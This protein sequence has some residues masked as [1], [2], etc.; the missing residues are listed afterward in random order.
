MAKAKTVFFCSECGNESLKWVGKCPGCGSWNTMVEE[1]KK[2]KS[3][4]NGLFQKEHSH[5]PNKITTINT[6]DA[7]RYHTSYQEFNRVLGGGIVRG[8][9]VLIGGDPGIGKS[10]L[11]LQVAANV[12]TKDTVLYVTGEESEQQIKNRAE[13]LGLTPDQLYIYSENNTH[14]I[15]KHI[16][17][18]NPSLVIVDSIQTVF[19]PDITSAPGS[20]SQV[21]E[22]TSNFMRL[23]KTKQIPIF[24]VGHVTKDGAIAGP[25]VLEHMVDTVL[26]FEGER[27]NTYR[28]LRAVK[29]RFGS[30]N[31]I[32]IFD[33]KEKGLEEVLNPSGVFLEDRSYGYAGASVV[34]AMEGTR[35]VL[36]EIQSLLSPTSFGNPKRMSQG[37]D[38][39]KLS[40]LIAVLE[41]RLGLLLQ[42]QDAYIKVT[43]GVKL[44]EPA[45]DVAILCSIVSSYKD[46]SL[47]PYDIFIGEVGLTGEIRR[48]ARIEE[49]IKEAHKMGF[50]RV[51]IPAKNKKSLSLN[52]KDFTIVGVN[53]IEELV[54]NAF[55]KQNDF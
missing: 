8:S 54:K 27:Y 15:I 16:E 25:R 30:T 24:I 36:V 38:Y 34:A 52:L 37:I 49:R 29:N 50:K 43:G 20:V 2:P 9:L 4:T 51:F 23:A 44:V 12:G 5:K 7:I 41:K 47:S 6:D 14:D 28:I 35:P 46:Q 45:V 1:P 32:G 21:R 11:L 48:V 18:L 10:T 53:D 13:R 17:L 3:T 33:M 55:E 31:E 19:V 26:Y 42:N 40:L 39:N 22:C